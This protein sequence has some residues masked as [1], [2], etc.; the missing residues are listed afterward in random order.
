MGRVAELGSFDS[1]TSVEQFI[2]QYFEDR[3]KLII[4]EIERRSPHRQNYFD[5]GCRWDS[6]QGTV[7]SSQAEKIL[8]VSQAGSETL[9]VTT[10][11]S[12]N[13]ITFPLRYHLRPKGG[14][15]LIHQVES[16]CPACH[17]TGEGHCGEESGG[18]RFCGGKGWK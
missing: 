14:T 15:W 7:E 12:H 8:S 10:G 11:R 6:R 9:V 4:A 3:T 18:C 5:S 2:A 1:M 13:S 16:Q 17:G